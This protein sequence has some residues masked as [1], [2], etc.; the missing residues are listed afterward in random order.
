MFNN[1][2][3]CFNQS[4]LNISFFTKNYDTNFEW[5][6]NWW[7]HYVNEKIYVAYSMDGKFITSLLQILYPLQN[8]FWFCSWKFY[9]WTVQKKLNKTTDIGCSDSVLPC[10]GKFFP[11]DWFFRQRFASSQKF[12][13]TW[14]AFPGILSL[15]SGKL[16]RW[17]DFLKQKHITKTQLQRLIVENFN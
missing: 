15:C 8:L 2:N 4:D 6:K 10:C 1:D 13:S 16:F 12:C 11:I 3:I 5:L 17:S 14:K 7:V 9:W